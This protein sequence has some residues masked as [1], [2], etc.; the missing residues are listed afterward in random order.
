[1]RF[2]YLVLV[3]TLVVASA[4]GKGEPAKHGEE[5]HAHSAG[6]GA[7]PA[8]AAGAEWCAE[9]GIAE[10]ACPK[11]DP[12]LAAK[13]KAAGDWCSAHGFPESQCPLCKTAEPGHQ[14]AAETPRE[15]GPIMAD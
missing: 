2:G 4:C 11:C 8:A 12:T 3:S 15:T 1:M 5:G 9:H 6:E 13:F 10:S 14:H 7:A